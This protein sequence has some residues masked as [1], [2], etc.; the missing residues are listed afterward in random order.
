V[1]HIIPKYILE[2]MTYISPTHAF[3][4]TSRGVTYR[5]KV[6]VFPS[7]YVLR[8][9]KLT[10][11][12]TSIVCST[13]G[14]D[15]RDRPLPEVKTF[16]STTVTNDEI[17]AA[18]IS[19]GGCIIKNV[20]KAEDLAAIEKDTRAHLL[21]DKSYNGTSFPMQTRRV[22][23]LA[24]KSKVFMEKLV[25]YKGYQDV[26]DTLLTSST[27]NW[28][29]DVQYQSNSKP[30]LHNTIVISIGPGAEPQPLHRDDMV[31]HRI[32]QKQEV[33]EYTIGQDSAIGFF[34]VGKKTTKANGA[35]RFIPAS[36]LWKHDTP[37]AENLTVYAE[38]EAGD[39]FIMLA[40]WY[41]G[42]S[43]NTTI[44]QERLVYSCFMTKGCL[45]KVRKAPTIQSSL[46]YY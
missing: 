38:L 43:A 34:V 41:H 9:P 2:G 42:G 8:C 16:D 14:G 37:P 11:I 18:L 23:G 5:S 3:A 19:T 7:T 1:I 29:G 33:S 12:I 24:S 13:G 31:H 35:T 25:C 17:I 45:R 27:T 32:N 44:D 20:M 15:D 10:S 26:C 46:Y 21:A 40:S 30:Q 22:N 4:D 6:T 36:H 39:G 28:V